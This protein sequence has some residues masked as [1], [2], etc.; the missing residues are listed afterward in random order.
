MVILKFKTSELIKPTP[1]SYILVRLTSPETS[2]DP[3]VLPAA[4]SFLLLCIRLLAPKIK[5]ID[6]FFALS[7]L[8]VASISQSIQTK[9]CCQ[10]QESMWTWLQCP[11]P[12]SRFKYSLN[13]RVAEEKV[14]T[15]LDEQYTAVHFSQAISQSVQK[16]LSSTF[17]VVRLCS[18]LWAH[19]REWDQ[20]AGPQ[21]A[22]AP[23][24]KSTKGH[25][26]CKK[27]KFQL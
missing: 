5:L 1:C 24:G 23:L 3:H 11:Q 20:T 21:G 6:H 14:L 2:S 13:C 8:V 7:A 26:K 9:A 27:Q 16:Y 4:K 17:S 18:R 12:L 10:G 19:H 15:D 25:P 22:H